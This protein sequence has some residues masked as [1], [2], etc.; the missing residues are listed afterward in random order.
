MD[1]LLRANLYFAI[2]IGLY[3]LLGLNN[4]KSNFQ[5]KRVFLLLLPLYALIL[6]SITWKT[7]IMKGQIN[8]EFSGNQIVLQNAS[9]SLS[10][11]TVF[12]YIYIIG[13]TVMTVRFLISLF[14][15]YSI[16]QS[17]Y[18]VKGIYINS[19]IQQPFTF[20]KWIV[21]PEKLS[22][23]EIIIQHEKLHQK[24]GHSWDILYYEI[25]KI[26][27]WFNPMVY[28][29]RFWAE[30]N[31]EYLTDE[32]ITHN[33]PKKEYQLSLIKVPETTI[34]LPLGNHFNKNLIKKRI[35]MMNQTQKSRKTGW[36]IPI[37]LFML[38]VS[39]G[40]NAQ[41]VKVINL[42]TQDSTEIKNNPKITVKKTKDLAY[43]LNGKSVSKEEIEKLDPERIKDVNVNTN[44]EKETIEIT[45]YAE[46]ETPNKDK[47]NN[48]IFV[49]K[50]NS[51]TVDVQAKFDGNWIDF[52]S[53]TIKYPT[54]AKTQGTVTIQFVVETDGSVNSVKAIAGPEGYYAESVRVI[55]VSS[56][57]WI[58][59]QKDGKAVSSV[60]TQKI[61]YQYE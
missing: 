37:A 48:I 57:K 47:K 16:I 7:R 13:V 2:G 9:F 26:I 40:L 11:E 3:K 50:E 21:I 12:L 5:Y 22:E 60:G 41:E 20:F 4:T 18:L 30:E 27:A 55:N 59:A 52:L 25:L 24:Q 15:I 23:N 28:L 6:S 56:G 58:P 61:T 44:Q 38:T 54:N 36:F 46:G 1:N 42:S 31:I 8:S 17:S 53:K 29:G 34:P 10:W 39:Y 32:A 14:S 35:K 19:T 33:Y 45:T 51:K 43:I 49:N